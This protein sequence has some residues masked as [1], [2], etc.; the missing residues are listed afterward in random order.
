MFFLFKEIYHFPKWVIFPP[1]YPKVV[2]ET[3]VLNSTLHQPFHSHINLSSGF[4]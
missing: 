2:L 1:L 4:G 3:M